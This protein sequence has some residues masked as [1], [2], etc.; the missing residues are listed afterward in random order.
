M[1]GFYP[2]LSILPLA[3]ATPAADDGYMPDTTAVNAPRR[4][5]LSWIAL[6]VVYLMWGLTY[7]AIRVGVGHLPPL[8]LAG[9]RYVIAGALLY[10]VAL[11]AANRS[12][13][14]GEGRARPGARAW[15]AGAVVGILLLFAGN[16]G[17]TVGETMLPSGFAAVLVATVP[18]WMIVFA[19]PVQHQ[20][21]TGKSAAGLA[22]GLGGVAILVGGGAASGHI[23]GV[24]IVL[25][26]SA[27]WGFGSVLGHRLALPSHAMLAAAIEMLA[28]GVV[29]LAVAAGTG[30]FSHLQ[31]SSV[32]ATSWIALACLIGPGSILAF[33]A[34]GYALS[35]LP[36]TTVS[37]Y[38]YV[39]PVVAVLA[40]TLVLGEH[41]AWREGLGA[42]LVVG[43]IVIILR[44]SHS[45]SRPAHA[46]NGLTPETE[47]PS[48]G[49]A[50]GHRPEPSEE[51]AARVR[52]G[53]AH[54]HGPAVRS[55]AMPRAASGARPGHHRSAPA[56]QR[57]WTYIGTGSHV[58]A[59]RVGQLG[60]PDA[61][62]RAHS[63]RSGSAGARS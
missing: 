4:P 30:E 56:G 42:A 16:G 11:R 1:A 50:R 12:R 58:K 46:A 61:G 55:A 51:V 53:I 32:P 2:R 54:R 24:I 47:M 62:R 37:T 33:T 45:A 23:S 5:L 14:P 44:R 9:T 38:A 3:A 22:V 13:G 20:R 41:L 63:V 35:H 10:P 25:G 34:Y 21:V 49:P 57:G 36:V 43:S 17:L 52:Y 15:L 59:V 8:V 40:G 26:G 27:A 29:L 6:A 19:W 39:N 28:G 18:L 60:C 31:W 48:E 7:L